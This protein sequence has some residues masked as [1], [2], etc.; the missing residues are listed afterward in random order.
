MPE[1]YFETIKNKS[2][3]LYLC[4]FYLYCRIVHLSK[5]YHKT[6]MFVNQ[7]AQKFAF[8]IAHTLRYQRVCASSPFVRMNDL[9]GKT[10]IL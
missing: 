8:L 1:K 6:V 9:Y 7:H 3:M 10:G 4:I 5:F 2:F